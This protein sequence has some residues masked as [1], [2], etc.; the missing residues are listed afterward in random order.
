VISEGDVT[1]EGERM[2]WSQEDAVDEV[3]A[4]Y[5][6]DAALEDVW[7]GLHHDEG[8]AEE[9]YDDNAGG[10]GDD[11]EEEADEIEEEGENME[12]RDDYENG[13]SALE[14]LGEEFEHNSVANGELSCAVFQIR[15]STYKPQ[16]SWKIERARH[17]NSAG[18]YVQDRRTRN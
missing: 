8:D 4:Q 12:E 9:E 2:S 15:I 17:V 3:D 1:T 7:S 14:M 10:E 5:A 11:N 16:Y 18:I 6:I 13:L